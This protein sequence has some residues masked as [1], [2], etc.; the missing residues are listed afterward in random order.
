MNKLFIPELGT[1]L[2]LAADWNFTLFA[3]WRNEVLAEMARFNYFDYKLSKNWQKLTGTYGHAE[4][5]YILFILPAGCILTVDRVFIRK[6]MSGFSSVSFFLDKKSIDP[7]FSS[8]AEKIYNSK[9]K[10][11]FWAKLEDVNN[12]CYELS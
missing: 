6:G 1:K 2:T 9:N 8:V 5:Y 7:K 3:E 4:D 11:R 10:I 12:I